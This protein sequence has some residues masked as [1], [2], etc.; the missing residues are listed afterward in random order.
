MNAGGR[1]SDSGVNEGCKSDSSRYDKLICLG[2]DT[3]FLDITKSHD[4]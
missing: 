1:A 4:I 2:D 3:M